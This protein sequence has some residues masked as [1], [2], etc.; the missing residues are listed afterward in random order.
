MDPEPEM[1]TQIRSTQHTQHTES[2]DHLSASPDN[3]FGKELEIKLEST[4]YAT[5]FLPSDN[6]LCLGCSDGVTRVV[7]TT[8]TKVQYKLCKND[9][10]PVVGLACCPDGSSIKNGVMVIHASGTL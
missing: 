6:L 3:L 4:A 7:S 5:E 2:K 1:M 8:N 10:S 9:T